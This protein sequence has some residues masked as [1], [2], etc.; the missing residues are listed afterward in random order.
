VYVQDDD[1]DDDDDDGNSHEEDVAP[2]PDLIKAALAFLTLLEQAAPAGMPIIAP[3]MLCY[4]GFMPPPPRG[5]RA[6][7]R[8]VCVCVCMCCI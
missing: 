7:V 5:V 6:C 4:R 2:P 8:V 1:D 3:A